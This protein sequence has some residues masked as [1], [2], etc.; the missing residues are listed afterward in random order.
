MNLY[1]K[2]KDRYI[3][4]N[5]LHWGEEMEYTIYKINEAQR[6]VQLGNKADQL[7]KDLYESLSPKGVDLQPEF[8]N[9]MIEGV[10]AQ[11]YGTIENC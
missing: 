4:N 7:I 10:P 3:E 6:S 1:R 5:D 11:P 8:G 9:W 2:H